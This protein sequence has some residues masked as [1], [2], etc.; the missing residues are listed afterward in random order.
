MLV[1]ILASSQGHAQLDFY[2][3]LTNLPSDDAAY[4]ELGFPN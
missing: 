3:T 4:R 2:I 1:H